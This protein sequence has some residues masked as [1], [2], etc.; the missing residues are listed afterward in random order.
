[1]D[2]LN[3]Q[4]QM[5]TNVNQRRTDPRSRS[6]YKFV[7]YADTLNKDILMKET[8]GSKNSRSTKRTST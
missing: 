2:I 4:S 7:Q 5:E 1:M 8:A 3:K 6:I